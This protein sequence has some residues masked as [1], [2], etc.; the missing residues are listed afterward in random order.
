[1][2]SIALGILLGESCYNWHLYGCG[3]FCWLKDHQHPCLSCAFPMR[4]TQTGAS[5]RWLVPDP[6]TLLGSS[7][8]RLNSLT[9]L[10]E[11]AKD[12]INHLEPVTNMVVD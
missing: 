7:S 1:M 8:C 5:G 3:L 11:I 2:D 6:A 12:S 9:L 4:L 10:V